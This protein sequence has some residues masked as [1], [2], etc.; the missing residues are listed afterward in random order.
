M[1][2]QARSS[3]ACT[4]VPGHVFSRPY[5]HSKQAVS[6]GVVVAGDNFGSFALQAC[7]GLQ[8]VTANKV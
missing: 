1:Q 4:F 6:R 8:I 7:R 2:L 5:I 3:P